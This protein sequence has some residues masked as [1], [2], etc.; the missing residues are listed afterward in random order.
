[1][2]YQTNERQLAPQPPTF[3]ILPGL[4]QGSLALA[5]PEVPIG[6]LDCQPHLPHQKKVLGRSNSLTCLAPR[7]CPE[8]LPT[9]RAKTSQLTRPAVSASSVTREGSLL[10][11]L[12][13][14][15]QPWFRW[16][17]FLLGKA[18]P[19]LRP[20]F[21]DRLVGVDL[22]DNTLGLVQVQNGDSVAVV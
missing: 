9:R 22:F 17:G 14:Y 20:N 4:W 19:H 16:T 7:T 12:I 21:I 1:M 10:L 18:A 6:S 3:W 15:C 2:P 8:N 11:A 5:L 13:H